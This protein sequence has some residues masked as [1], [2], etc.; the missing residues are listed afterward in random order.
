[1]DNN[2]I[3]DQPCEL[4]PKKQPGTVCGDRASKGKMPL[5]GQPSKQPRR[6]LTKAELRERAGPQRAA[7]P[8]PVSVVKRTFAAVGSRTK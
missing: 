3:A 8:R 6:K 2:M 1:M 5:L 7:Q 4:I